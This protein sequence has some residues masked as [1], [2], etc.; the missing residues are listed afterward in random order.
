MAQEDL[1]GKRFGHLTVLEPDRERKSSRSYWLC[2]CD[3]GKICS[4]QSGHL[5]DGHTR[6]CGCLRKS[7]GK[8]RWID[9]TGHQYGRLTVLRRAASEDEAAYLRDKKGST[10]IDGE[11]ELWLCRCSCGNLCVCSKETLRIGKTQSCGCLRDDQ[12]K[13]NMKKAIHFSDGTCIERIASRK[14]FSNNTSGHRGVY[15]RKNG[16]WKA[17]IGF[18]GKVYHLGNFEYYDDAVA[19]RLEAEHQFYD[20]YLEN[21]RKNEAQGEEKDGNKGTDGEREDVGAS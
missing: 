12:R 11:K 18:R 5:K 16:K 1:T 8:D 4:I 9:L 3:C 2:R 6:S 17:S 14:E 15:L 7:N 19:A 10:G 20:A 13:E 21:Y